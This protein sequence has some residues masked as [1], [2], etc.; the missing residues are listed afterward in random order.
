M[1]LF[2]CKKETISEAFLEGYWLA[3]IGSREKPINV[4]DIFHFKKGKID[5]YYQ[6]MGYSPDS[7]YRLEKDSFF[8]LTTKDK[9]IN[10]AK[11]T[12]LNRD[13][14]LISN[15]FYIDSLF[16]LNEKEATKIIEEMYKD[17][18]IE[19]ELPRTKIEE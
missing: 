13:T 16:R 19:I 4:Q 1:F 7:N 15:E 10:R 8:L 14:L 12:I 9:I 6:S 17:V 2:S 18:H 11:F 5:Y 3:K